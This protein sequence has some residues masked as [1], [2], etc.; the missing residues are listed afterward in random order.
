MCVCVLKECARV[1]W[2]GNSMDRKIV[3]EE[4]TSATLYSLCFNGQT[5]QHFIAFSGTYSYLNQLQEHSIANIVRRFNVECESY[6][7]RFI[8]IKMQLTLFIITHPNRLFA[9]L[10]CNI[11]RKRS[12]G[13]RVLS[14]ILS[15]LIWI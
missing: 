11:V 12:K 15:N 6:C 14:Q 7:H 9:Y 10:L 1:Q 2:H 13:I 3:G 4:K 8:Y 5:N